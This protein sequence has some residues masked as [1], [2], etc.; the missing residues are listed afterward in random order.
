M[1]RGLFMIPF[2]LRAQRMVL[3]SFR[4]F[5]FPEEYG[6]NMSIPFSFETDNA[7]N[8]SE[9]NFIVEDTILYLF[10]IS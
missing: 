3:Q 1:I 4:P 10:P 8:M 2:L 7:L 6:Q 5:V 9:Y